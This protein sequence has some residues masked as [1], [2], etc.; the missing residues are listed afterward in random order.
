MFLIYFNSWFSEAN[1][2]KT[3]TDDFS[4]VEAA[5]G[6]FHGSRT[7]ERAVCAVFIVLELIA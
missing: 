5:E 2:Q 4:A 3:F 1:Y 6:D 7:L